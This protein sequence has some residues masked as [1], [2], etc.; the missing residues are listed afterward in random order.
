[1]ADDAA[2]HPLA[3]RLGSVWSKLHQHRRWDFAATKNCLLDRLV[4]CCPPLDMLRVE[5]GFV[6]PMHNQQT[7]YCNAP[8]YGARYKIGVFAPGQIGSRLA[9]GAQGLYSAQIGRECAGPYRAME[10]F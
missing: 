1:M 2:G 9:L 10:C 7:A 6:G 8:K 3:R 5:P 4:H